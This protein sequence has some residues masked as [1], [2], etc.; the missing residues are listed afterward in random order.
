[1]VPAD[2][3]GFVAGTAA[4]LAAGAEAFRALNLRALNFNEIGDLAGRD[5]AGLPPN[6]PRSFFGDFAA[7]M[8][9]SERSDASRM[10]TLIVSPSRLNRT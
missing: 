6:H 9:R 3:G 8:G 7:A 2:V 10:G 4:G 5:E 1:M